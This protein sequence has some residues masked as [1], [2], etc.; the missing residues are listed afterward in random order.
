MS[1]NTSTS[2]GI[3]IISTYGT[4]INNTNIT[5]FNGI[6]VN[7]SF[8]ENVTLGAIYVNGTT[9]YAIYV[10]NSNS[11]YIKNSKINNIT[12]AGITLEKSNNSWVENNTMRNI[13]NSAA[14]NVSGLTKNNTFAIIRFP[15]FLMAYI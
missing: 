8:A 13:S 10:N 2:N 7:I 4:N 9:S 14:I 12:L 1:I 6:G 5:S 11:T 15:M 3:S